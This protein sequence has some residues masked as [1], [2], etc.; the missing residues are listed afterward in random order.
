LVYAIRKANNACWSLTFRLI[1]KKGILLVL[2]SAILV[3]GFVATS[4]FY[5]NN[6]VDAKKGGNKNQNNNN[7]ESV[8]PNLGADNSNLTN[9]SLPG[10]IS[11]NNTISSSNLTQ[12][13]LGEQPMENATSTP[14]ANTTVTGEEP[15]TTGEGPTSTTENATPPAEANATVTG[16][17]PPAENAT[18]PE[19]NATVTGGEQTTGGTTSTTENA[20]SPEVNAT[21]PGGEQTTGGTTSTTEN[22]TS[23]P[24]TNATTQQQNTN[25]NNNN[26]SSAANVTTENAPPVG[27]VDI[28]STNAN[29]STDEALPPEQPSTN[30]ATTTNATSSETTETTSDTLDQTTPPED[31]LGSQVSNQTDKAAAAAAGVSA[32][33]SKVENNQISNIQN[34]INN[35]AISAAQSGGNSQNVA[36]QIS[37]E[38]ITNPK[39]PVANSIKQLANEFSQGNADEVNIAADQIGSLVA[40][41]NNIQQT[42]VQVTNNVVNNIKNIKATE[43]NYDKVIISPSYTTQQKSDITQTLNTIKKG[44]QEVD[45]P[46]IHIKFHTHE[47]NLVLRVL[48]TNNYKYD[49]PFSKFNGAFTLDDNEFRVKIL[50]GDGSIKAASVAK[51]FKSGKI[52]DRDF[53]NKDVNNGKVFFSLKGV[54][55]GKYLLEVYVKLSNG[56]IGTFARG[57]V[58]IK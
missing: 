36:Q 14:E 54:D 46:R 9:S 5:S 44:K 3:S 42:L 43:N 10:L 8:S 53:L 45:V 22:A 7:E 4:Q 38:I 13:N 19:A 52:G 16:E 21:V 55:S 48:T 50:S 49:M 32:S 30:N 18:S 41:G 35:I 17:A 40:K 39:G 31:T 23:P 57:S 51:M 11:E 6:V 15:T 27:G 58:S 26:E 29:A 24:E 28:L 33:N 47:R 2:V 20:T 56:A 1:L 37:N 25:T 12:S 34:V